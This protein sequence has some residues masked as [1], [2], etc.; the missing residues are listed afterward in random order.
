LERVE[1]YKS[2]V[3]T[4][5]GIQVGDSE[6]RAMKVYGPKLRVSRHAYTGPEG[7]YLTLRSADGRYGI[8]FE[9]DHGK[10][11]MFYAGRYDAIQYIEGCE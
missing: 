10:I 2:G 7:H 3:F 8:R 4:A 5:D 1:V 9:T 6:A 11:T